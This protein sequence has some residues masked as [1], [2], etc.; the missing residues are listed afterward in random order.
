MRAWDIPNWNNGE[1]IKKDY[2]TTPWRF[3]GNSWEYHFASEILVH[4]SGPTNLHHTDWSAWDEP[5]KTRKVK[6]YAPV[7][8]NG[9][10]YYN[11]GEYRNTAPKIEET[12]VGR[13]EIE[14]EVEA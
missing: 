8:H 7:Y 10:G 4:E 3:N 9:H 1:W 6:M 14:V 13:H 12:V 5:K 2:C 11:L